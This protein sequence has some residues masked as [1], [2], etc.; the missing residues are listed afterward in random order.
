MSMI[1]SLTGPKQPEYD[2]TIT[3]A[4]AHVAF[5]SNNNQ[6][7]KPLFESTERNVDTSAVSV[8]CNK[9]C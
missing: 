7:N 9:E 5:N 6:V 8:F 2:F 1:E 4:G 3:G